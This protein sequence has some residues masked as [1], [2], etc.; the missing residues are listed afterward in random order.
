MFR[1]SKIAHLLLKLTIHNTPVKHSKEPSLTLPFH[2]PV[3]YNPHRQHWLLLDRIVQQ[4]I[5][6]QG[7]SGSRST[8]SQDAHPNADDKS[9]TSTSYG[10]VSLRLLT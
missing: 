2:S 4:L 8:S 5:L 6:Q 10:K 7:T 9:T 1:F 3:E